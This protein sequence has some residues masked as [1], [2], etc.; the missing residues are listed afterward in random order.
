VTDAGMDTESYSL[1]ADGPWLTKKA[2]Q[3]F[4]DNYLPD[5]DKRKAV[6]ASPLRATAN[7][8]AGLPPA[9]ILTA[10]NDVLRDEG[11][12]FARKLDEAGVAAASLRV[13]GTIHDFAMLD[14]LADTPPTHA[15]MTVAASALRWGLA[16]R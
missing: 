9:L 15:A 12:E 13:N 14:A 2:M 3:W 5:A 16:Q 7:Q 8:L 1:F 11:E 6:T 10:E 4:W